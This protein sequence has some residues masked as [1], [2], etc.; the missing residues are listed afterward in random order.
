MKQIPLIAKALTTFSLEIY[1]L[2]HF[3]LM[4]KT[5]QREKNSTPYCNRIF[6]LKK[7]QDFVRKI[8]A[9]ADTANKKTANIKKAVPRL[10][11]RATKPINAGPVKSPA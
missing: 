8:P 4:Y 3:I 7:I 2:I 1:S 6:P 10:V 9:A 11:Q 5:T